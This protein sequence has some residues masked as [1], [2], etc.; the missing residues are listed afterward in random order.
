MSGFAE[1]LRARCAEIEKFYFLYL[2][3]R[4]NYSFIQLKIMG[5]LK[6]LNLE[7]RNDIGTYF[8]RVTS[9]GTI[10]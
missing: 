8:F 10:F 5:E 6:D 1:R 9:S 4:A 7:D 3:K 2:E